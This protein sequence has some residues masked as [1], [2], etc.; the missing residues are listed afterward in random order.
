MKIGELA[1]AVGLGSVTVRYY[2]SMGLL[3]RPK[4]TPAN[5]R[6]Y[7]TD[8]A[9]RLEFIRK[10]KRLGLSLEE[11][12]SILQL[13]DRREPTCRHVRRLLDEKLLHVD[14]L[15]HDLQEFRLDL[16]RLRESAGDMEDCRPSGGHIC[17]I[18]E[19]SELRVGDQ[20]VAWLEARRD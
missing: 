8:D 14:T 10:A 1:R 18:I 17:G 7:G 13:H 16:A 2:E 4:R 6:I 11:I 12:K 15:L 20:G 9:K 5:Y 3:P 19:R